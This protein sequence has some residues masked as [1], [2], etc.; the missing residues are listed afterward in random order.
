MAIKLRQRQKMSTVLRYKLIVGGASLLGMMAYLT[1]VM[2][3]ASVDETKA[4]RRDLMANDPINNG[5]IV[6]GFS[7]DINP[8]TK[9]DVGPNAMIA[10]TNAECIEGGTDSSTVPLKFPAMYSPM[11]PYSVMFTT[12]AGVVITVCAPIVDV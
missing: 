10:S 11:A 8:V 9:A 1:I 12:I 5:E 4:A 7:W 6:A 3:T 2:N